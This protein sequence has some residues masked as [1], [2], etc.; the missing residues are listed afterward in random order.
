MS[1]NEVESG[2]HRHSACILET[3]WSRQ[4]QQLQ[5][6]HERDLERMRSDFERRMKLNRDRFA[7]TKANQQHS[8]AVALK[9]A[10]DNMQSLRRQSEALQKEM[11]QRD[12]AELGKQ[13]EAEAVQVELLKEQKALLTEQRRLEARFQG[14]QGQ[15]DAEQQKASALTQ[16]MQRIEKASRN[17]YIRF[18]GGV[19]RNQDWSAFTAQ[20]VA[21]TE[22]MSKAE[23]ESTARQKREFVQRVMTNLDNIFAAYPGN[24]QHLKQEFQVI[25]ARSEERDLFRQLMSVPCIVPEKR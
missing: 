23:H 18:V 11:R 7:E 14:V 2:P 3:Q 4:M 9:T 24:V 19:L 21:V 25:F 15:L 8:K 17:H 6:S 1:R 13:R 16:S 12:D 10:A 5:Q 22:A 20:V